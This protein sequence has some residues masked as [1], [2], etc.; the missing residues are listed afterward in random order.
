MSIE[1]EFDSTDLNYFSMQNT[2]NFNDGNTAHNFSK[3]FTGNVTLETGTTMDF[4][5]SVYKFATTPS[6]DI[7][8]ETAN[9]KITVEKL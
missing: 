7:T 2:D 5:F 9:Y 3:T 8:D 1:I 6:P 4:S